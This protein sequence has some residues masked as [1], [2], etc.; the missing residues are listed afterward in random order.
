MGLDCTSPLCNDKVPEEELSNM[1]GP[2][3]ASDVLRYELGHTCVVLQER[4]KK[5][6]MVSKSMFSTMAKDALHH[7]WRT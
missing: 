6:C 7:G 4:F 3:T 2:G 1:L 5:I